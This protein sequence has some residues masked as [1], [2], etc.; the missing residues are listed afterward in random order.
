MAE[1]IEAYVFVYHEGGT[2]R[3][4]VKDGRIVGGPWAGWEL[5]TARLGVAEVL[6]VGGATNGKLDKARMKH[7]RILAKIAGEVA[8]TYGRSG[9]S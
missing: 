3:V 9:N 4:I 1:V 6:K 8:E 2:D 7:A 5:E